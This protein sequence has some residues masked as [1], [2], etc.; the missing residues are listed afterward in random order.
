MFADHS[1]LPLLLTARLYPARC[2]V[3]VFSQQSLSIAVKDVVPG[4]VRDV[5]EK[6][7]ARVVMLAVPG[8]VASEYHLVRSG[9]LH[10]VFDEAVDVWRQGRGAGHEA[11]ARHLGKVESLE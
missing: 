11:A 7:G 1:F 8:Q 2:P 3:Q 10:H 6:D 5:G 9:S 4:L